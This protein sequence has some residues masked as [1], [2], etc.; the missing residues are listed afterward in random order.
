MYLY[1]SIFWNFLL[2]IVIIVCFF[3]SGSEKW[4]FCG[5]MNGELWVDFVLVIVEVIG[6]SSIGCYFYGFYGFSR[7]LLFLFSYRV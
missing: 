7:V 6:G 5:G 3:F 2:R 4:V 1:V